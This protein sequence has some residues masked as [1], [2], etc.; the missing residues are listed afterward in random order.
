MVAAANVLSS[1]SALRT[2][3][4]ITPQPLYM[5]AAQTQ[6][7]NLHYIK[8]YI[9]LLNYMKINVIKLR[10]KENETKA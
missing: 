3:E 2:F 9:V 7:H 10:I 4:I 5:S 6:S 8:H 1:S